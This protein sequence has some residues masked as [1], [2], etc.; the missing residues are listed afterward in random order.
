LHRTLKNPAVLSYYTMR[1]AVGVTAL[2]LPFVLAFGYIFLSLIGPAHALPNPLIERSIS[3]YYHTPMRNYLVGSL[4]AIAAFLACSRGYDLRDEIAGYLAALLAVAV[5]IIPAVNPH[6]P[7]HTRYYEQLG[8]AHL[9]AAAL[10]FLVLAYFCLHLFRK[11]SPEKPL[12]RRKRHRNRVY[13]VCGI[14]ITAALS[15]MI[16]LT[17]KRVQA[18]LWPTGIVFYTESMGL[19]AFGLAWLV[20][21]EVFLRDSSHN[22]SHP[23]HD[24]HQRALIDSSHELPVQHEPVIAAHNYPE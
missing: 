2:S 21:G 14:V 13:L 11:T 24:P 3:D 17:I 9:I 4:C 22:H 19:F 1:R 12:T 7:T 20:K 16:S 23:N 10:M 15:V 6:H 8:R 18:A 5:A